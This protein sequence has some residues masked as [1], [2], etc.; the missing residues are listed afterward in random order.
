[1]FALDM[2]NEPSVNV[3]AEL[4]DVLV[5]AATPVVIALPEESLTASNET[6]QLTFPAYLF[7]A[8]FTPKSAHEI[9]DCTCGLNITFMFAGLL[10]SVNLITLIIGQS[11]PSMNTFG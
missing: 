1:M 4:I 10:P 11:H 8:S 6:L 5:V 3:F 7:G 2:K 9:T